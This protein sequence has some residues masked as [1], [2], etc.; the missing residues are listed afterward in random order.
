[1]ILKRI[2][3][4]N[5]RQ[6]KGT[7]GTTF[8]GRSGSSNVTVFYGE[9]GRGK[10]GIFRAM[11]FCLYGD[12]IISQDGDVPDTKIDLV[13]KQAIQAAAPNTVV[14]S[15]V[16]LEFTHHERTYRLTRG[17]DG[18]KGGHGEVIQEPTGVRLEIADVNG[19]TRVLE[20]PVAVEDEVHFVLDKGIRDYFLFDGEKI[21]RLTRASTEQRREIARG[22]RKLLNVDAL[23]RAIK[24][25]ARLKKKLDTELTSSSRSDLARVI[26]DLGLLEEEMVAI[27]SEID[28][29]ESE[30]AHAERE[31]HGVDQALEQF[32]E[33]R[34]LVELRQQ[35]TDQ[36][37]DREE[38][39]SA[40]LGEMK[41]YSSRSATLLISDLVTATLEYFNQQ[42]RRG[43]IPPEIRNEL[44]ERILREAR[45]IC[46]REILEGTT[47]YECIQKWHEK[48][49]DTGF[50]DIA[51]QLWHELG[52]IQS[53]LGDL[54]RN[55]ESFLMR[56]SNV[57][58]DIESLELRL[59]QISDKIGSSERKDALY[60]EKQ[61]GML[62]KKLIDLR[63][64]HIT[65]DGTLRDARDRRRELE[66]RKSSLEQ[67]V[68][69]HDEVSQR[70]L[71]ARKVFDALQ[72]IHDEFTAEIRE[73]IGLYA[74]ELFER[75]LDDQGKKVLSRVVVNDDY[76]IEVYDR[77]GAQFLPNISSGQR[78]LMSISF[79][80]ALARVAA[81]EQLLEMPLF[82]DTP[83]GR[84]SNEH[85]EH[86]IQEI[87]S[88]CSQWI[89]LATDTEFRTQEAHA[90][91][92]NKKWGSFAF[93]RALEDGCTEIRDMSYESA[94][95]LLAQKENLR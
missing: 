5:F 47:A 9:N 11:L 33:I 56:H 43:E 8:S 42:K 40:L 54:G 73:L 23:E 6:F 66:E 16:E 28:T 50:K 95:E 44:I 77:W 15:Y 67:E 10:T 72:M 39:A 89:L 53:N 46:G 63:A 88:F 93:L 36:L 14:S 41:T 21:E 84:L 51:L 12:R 68:S 65:L 19:N 60:L 34:H 59:Q 17:L 80:A 83:F 70:A 49:S 79:I 71:L 2:T 62:E 1:M 87:P 76:S 85:R 61:R 78:Q 20:D 13:N 32:K 38:Q 3:L 30:T 64:R 25:M 37:K 22:V 74:T 58:N 27:S 45:C 29:V 75:L 52:K 18:M 26:K 69:R 81:K 4:C 35:N 31:K 92:K 24:S 48:T 57:R 55:V 86:L 91:R 82:M 90:L 7:Q 94:L